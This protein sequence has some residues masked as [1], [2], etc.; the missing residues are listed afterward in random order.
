MIL[1]V[2]HQDAHPAP[3][4]VLQRRCRL[5]RILVPG[6]LSYFFPKLSQLYGFYNVVSLCLALDIPRRP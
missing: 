3:L 2:H 5:R 4:G 1:Q 6:A